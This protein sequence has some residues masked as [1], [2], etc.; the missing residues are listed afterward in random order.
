MQ[1]SAQ[2]LSVHLLNFFTNASICV[3]HTPS[4]TSEISLIPLSFN[5]HLHLP[6]ATVLIT[7]YHRLGSG[8]IVNG[9]VRYACFFV[10]LLLLNVR[11]L[12]VIPIVSCIS[13]LFLFIITWLS[14]ILPSLL[15]MAPGLFTISEMLVC[16][17]PIISCPFP[18]MYEFWLLHILGR[19]WCC[20]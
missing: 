9:I 19:D 5:C 12:W 13:T 10:R 11:I 4:L 3:T 8:H 18:S 1:W 14:H 6:K 2:I 15:W 20:K 16:N 17:N 7:F